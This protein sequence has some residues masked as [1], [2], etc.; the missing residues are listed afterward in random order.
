MISLSFTIKPFFLY[1]KIL[2]T[3]LELISMVKMGNIYFS[4]SLGTTMTC[5]KIAAKTFQFTGIYDVTK[6][7]ITMF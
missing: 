7:Q 3:Q 2:P 4:P 5:K 6:W 1:F